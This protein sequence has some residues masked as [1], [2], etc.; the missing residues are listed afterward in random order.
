MS[1]S[2]LNLATLA[3][4]PFL[5]VSSDGF[6]QTTRQKAPEKAHVDTYGAREKCFAEA[7]AK[8]PGNPDS[9][10]WTKAGTNRDLHGLRKAHGLSAV[11]DGICR[12]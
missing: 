8:H 4:L 1:Y 3:V 11:N 5:L 7:S 2:R 12:R 9:N 6:S 10:T